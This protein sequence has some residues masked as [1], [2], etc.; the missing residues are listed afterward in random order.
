MFYWTS[1]IQSGEWGNM[2]GQRLNR[3]SWRRV[4]T[5][6]ARPYLVDTKSE[7]IEKGVKNIQDSI[8]LYLKTLTEDGLPIPTPFPLKISS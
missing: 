5:F 2:E 3:T 7:T 6:F 1:F 8:E 4:I